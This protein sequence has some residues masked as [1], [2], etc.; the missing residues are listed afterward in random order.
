[1]LYELFHDKAPFP[2][3]SVEDVKKKIKKNQIN[4]KKD[5]QPDIKKWIVKM[6][7]I[8]PKHRPHVKDILADPFFSQYR[9]KIESEKMQSR[10]SHSTSGATSIQR[11]SNSTGMTASP[12]FITLASLKSI[13]EQDSTQNSL[14]NSLQKSVN[15]GSSKQYS[16]FK[17]PTN[18]TSV[19]SNGQK[20]FRFETFKKESSSTD[21]NG[22]IRRVISNEISV[23]QSPSKKRNIF[24][25]HD[26]SN[27]EK[28]IATMIS[29]KVIPPPSN[30]IP[31]FNKNVEMRSFKK[32][33]TTEQINVESTNDKNKIKRVF[34]SKI[35]KPGNY[36]NQKTPKTN[37]LNA[38]KQKIMKS[39]PKNNTSNN[40]TNKPEN[41]HIIS[42]FKTNQK[43]PLIN[44]QKNKIHYHSE[45]KPISGF[46]WGNQQLKNYQTTTTPQ[47]WAPK[48]FYSGSFQGSKLG[49]KLLNKN[50]FI[51][52]NPVKRQINNIQKL[53]N[54]PIQSNSNT[55]KGKLIKHS[56]PSNRSNLIK[57]SKGEGP[58]NLKKNAFN[59][60]KGPQTFSSSFQS[61]R[62]FSSHNNLNS[63]HKDFN[64]NPQ[65]VNMK[66]KI[67]SSTSQPSDA[68]H[69]FKKPPIQSMVRFLQPKIIRKEVKKN[70]SFRSNRIISNIKPSMINSTNGHLSRPYVNVNQKN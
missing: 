52:T 57:I 65:S 60:V 9:K 12:K 14:N 19:N 15:T 59:S 3:R 70:Q 31:S 62:V 17:E 67:Y 29:D 64:I 30:N 58:V 48:K 56:A 47:K 26:F 4:F 22:M 63:T 7:N 25:N 42:N 16:L 34:K 39:N 53:K 11:N 66:K 36:Q 33:K 28:K 35:N 10:G 45:Q 55:F 8:Y 6:L 1:M 37:K 44:Q 49:N 21:L 24:Y 18:I 41:K 23:T 69:F 61:Q 2:G 13:K 32:K 43:S 68:V 51:S 54:K 5:I 46:K 27:S 20:K 40:L 50:Q 38:L